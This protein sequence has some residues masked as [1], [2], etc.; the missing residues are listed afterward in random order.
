[1]TSWSADYT[2]KHTPT[3]AGARMY[4]QHTPT[5]LRPDF[6]ESTLKISSTQFPPIMNIPSHINLSSTKHPLPFSIPTQPTDYKQNPYT[7]KPATRSPH[8]RY[9][10]NHIH[11]LPHIPKTHTLFP[12]H[13][14][15]NLELQTQATFSPYTLQT[16]TSSPSI[17]EGT[18]LEPSDHVISIKTTNVVSRPRKT[19]N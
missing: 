11:T 5:Q 17:T 9:T 6:H 15:H 13:Q 4:I 10:L 14:T 16:H 3:Q 18:W 1:M 7:S 12:L 19:M 2:N 8:T